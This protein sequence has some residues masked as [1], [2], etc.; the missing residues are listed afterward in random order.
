V[1]VKA[2]G[3]HAKTGNCDLIVAHIPLPKVHGVISSSDLGLSISPDARWL[4]CI[5]RGSLWYRR[6]G[7]M[8]WSSL[9]VRREWGRPVWL[10]WL[11]DPRGVLVLEGLQ[12][13][14]VGLLN[15]SSG[16]YVVLVSEREP[17]Q[18]S[19]VGRV[20]AIPHHVDVR[21]P[22][23]S[24]AV[25]AAR[26]DD[27]NGRGATYLFDQNGRLRT[28]I[29]AESALVAWSPDCRAA[30]GMSDEKGLMPRTMMILDPRTFQMHREVFADRPIDAEWS[31]D[32]KHLALIT[33]KDGERAGCAC[34]G[35]YPGTLALFDPR[36]GRVTR[37]PQYSPTGRPTWSADS[38]Y[39]AL[40]SR[41]IMDA[42]T[43]KARP[44]PAQL[45]KWAEGLD[46]A[47]ALWSPDGRYVLY[48]RLSQK[49]GRQ[50]PWLLDT[51]TWSVIAARRDDQYLPRTAK[52]GDYV[53]P[54]VLVNYRDGRTRYEWGWHWQ[55]LGQVTC[56][57]EWNERP[58]HRRL[59]IGRVGGAER[60]LV[61]DRPLAATAWS[62]DQSNAERDMCR[63]W[64]GVG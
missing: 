38:R 58:R 18:G 53:Y 16:E 24:V 32:G 43:G 21:S 54:R 17:E 5:W 31:P 7:S 23:G 57:D 36:T 61:V 30:I 62:R 55:R 8:R 13:K 59:F 50:G 51:R 33:S 64:P 26:A 39:L 20:W 60:M 14:E 37:Y 56:Y 2:F 44:L 15:A 41:S 6:L 28:T 49:K 63:G 46:G 10:R 11:S 1:V 4:A 22:C 29:D 42:A 35:I 48:S 52:P 9:P 25:H 27:I 3:C 34:T 45:R 40:G 12:N 47:S 19:G